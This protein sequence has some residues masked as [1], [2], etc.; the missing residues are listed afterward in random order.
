MSPRNRKY[1]SGFSMI[2]VLVLA[3]LIRLV[4]KVV[5]SVAFFCSRGQWARKFFSGVS[6]P[7]MR[8]G[9]DFL[10]GSGIYGAVISTVS[11]SMILMIS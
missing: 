7:V 3:L 9:M 10:I 6:T 11:P 1:L 4:V 2:M 8:S 5:A